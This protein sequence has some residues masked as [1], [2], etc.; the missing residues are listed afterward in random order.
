MCLSILVFQAKHMALTTI[1][2]KII[3]EFQGQVIMSLSYPHLSTL[4]SHVEVAVGPWKLMMGWEFDAQRFEVPRVR[5][6]W[7]VDGT[8][9]NGSDVAFPSQ[10]QRVEQRWDAVYAPC[11]CF[12]HAF[13][14]L[15]PCFSHG[16]LPDT[17]WSN[18]AVVVDRQATEA[19]DNY[20]DGASPANSQRSHWSHH[21]KAGGWFANVRNIDV[22][23]PCEGFHQCGYPK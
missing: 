8:S 12:S 6:I 9:W 18:G 1:H 13:P 21:L 23:F 4:L 2:G 22:I 7:S 15:F 11:P 10:K 19:M 17:T 5:A 20:S 3:L 14:M 16:F